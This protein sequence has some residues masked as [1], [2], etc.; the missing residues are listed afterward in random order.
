[1]PIEIIDKLKQ[2]NN[3]TFKLV[4]AIDVELL[5]GQD[6]QSYL[7]DMP[8]GGT[9]GSEEIII[10]TVAPTE[11]YKVWIDT[12][13]NNIDNTIESVILDEF[14][15][16]IS[17]LTK[18]IDSLEFE[19]A[20]LNEIINNGYTPPTST[21]NDEILVFEDGSL[22]T[23][24]DGSILIFNDN[25][26]NDKLLTFEDSSLMTFEDGSVMMFEKQ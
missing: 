4:D 12:S 16:I 1:M 2:K 17:S 22:L 19:V 7:D 5:N 10:G 21:T 8:S 18:R 14:R 6:L 11:D 26:T 9:G 20:K 13:S 23:F 25:L 15:L 24:E 3:G